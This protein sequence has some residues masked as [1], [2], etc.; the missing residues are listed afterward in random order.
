[1]T[2]APPP[3]RRTWLAWTWALV[4][5]ACAAHLALIWQ[6]G[7]LP[8]DT[9]VMA[10]LPQDTR[11]PAAEQAL[12]RLADGASRRVIVVLAAPDFARVREA[13]SAIQ[14]QLADSHSPLQPAPGAHST[15]RELIE[16]Y[17]PWR[18]R[19]LASADR[20][21][22]ARQTPA[23]AAQGALQALYRPGPGLRALSPL[24]DP[25]GSFPAW[26]SERAG[27]TRLRP[28]EGWLWQASDG[29][30]LI[31]LPF[32]LRATAL[33]V[34]ALQQLQPRLTAARAAAAAHEVELLAAGVPVHAAAAALQ[35]E[36]E[37]SLIG[38]GAAL[39]IALLMLL[40]FRRLRPMLLV[41]GSVGVGLIVALSLCLLLFERVHLLTL[42]FGASL[43]GVAEDYAIHWLSARALAPP[44]ERE[45]A[46]RALVPGLWLA[47]ATSA[48]GYLALALAP[49]PGLQQMALFSIVGLAGALISVLLW[50]PR[51]IGRE[52]AATAISLWLAGSFRRWPR[53]RTTPAALGILVLL[54]LLAA[55]GAA[56]LR[57]SDDL[58]ALQS[59]PPALIAEQARI[60]AWLSEP[61]PVQFYLVQGQDH[62]ELL[63]REEALVAKLEALRL[64]GFID[65][66]RALS[67]WVPSPV[68][69]A[70][71]RAL[72][73]PAA[74]A[75]RQAIEADLGASNAAAMP[76]ADQPLTLDQWLASP[77]AQPLRPL[78]LGQ[79]DGAFQSVVQV[80]GL[81]SAEQLP[82]LQAQARGLPGVAWVDRIGDYSRLLREYRI[83]MI[84]VL[85]ASIVLVAILLAWRY[86]RQA[87]RVMLPTLVA[88]LAALAWLGWRGEPLQLFHVL[89]LIVLLG[90]ADD[91]GI[92]LLEA[93]AAGP[94][95]LGVVLGAI[96]TL[97][98]FG[99]LAFSGTPA[100]AA[101]GLTLLIGIGVAWGLAPMA[102][103]VAGE[104]TVGFRLAHR[105]ESRLP[106]A[107]RLYAHRTARRSCCQS[108]TRLWP[109][110]GQEARLEDQ[111]EAGSEEKGVPCGASRS[112]EGERA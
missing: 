88:M 49:F 14:A 55:A 102:P 18:D 21:R 35:A 47:F 19:L 25:L 30:E 13:A 67:D 97:L 24:D 42:V 89:G 71:D 73:Q 86:R 38:A 65:G 10:L 39:G 26:L 78:Y 85:I 9:D 106:M 46:T 94:A 16:F 101:F 51:L 28:R 50:M 104:R 27:A 58:R 1:M 36:R 72:S 44:D 84:Q 98:A 45:R 108:S 5:L 4:V 112:D 79:I 43:V 8:V 41:L 93:D 48:L 81:K 29:R 77:L 53:L 57:S 22:L 96:N 90:M 83:A 20:E 95:W 12:S 63:A 75:A 33:S 103:M 52:P 100:L 56:R 80:H 62:A 6:R 64:E 74:R 34:S 105:R 68:R 66:H 31:V 91:Y 23:Q 109:S 99:L 15:S 2:E 37:M 59:S 54:L 11:N 87:W 70:Q 82:R 7:D 110:I 69:Q 76:L 40:C 111:A 107:E 92:F 32:E 17:A 3:L 61:S 60:G